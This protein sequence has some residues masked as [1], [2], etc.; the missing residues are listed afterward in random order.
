MGDPDFTAFYAAGKIVRAG[1]GA[2]LYTARTQLGTQREFTSDSDIRRG[3]LPYIHPPFEALIFL[4]LTFLS[5]RYA[6]VSWELLNLAML[7]GAVLKLRDWSPALEHIPPWQLALAG[8]AFFPVFANFHQ[9]QDAILMLLVVVLA[10]RDLER[11]ADLRAGCWLGLGVFRYQ[12][13]VPLVLILGLWGRRKLLLGFAATTLAAGLLS[14]AVVGWPG[15]VQY[16][17]FVWHWASELSFGRTPPALM[18]NLLGLVTGWPGLTSP[19]WPGQLVVLACS[20]GLLIWIVA[21]GRFAN[22]KRGSQLGFACAVLAALLVGYSTNSYDLALLLLPLAIV[23]DHCLGES[24]MRQAERTAL[25]APAIPLLISPLWFFLWLRW[26]RINL[27]AVFLL[28][29][30]YAIAQEMRRLEKERHLEA[31]YS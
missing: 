26:E 18:P 13:I 29:W 5:Y 16:V 3:P 27:I 12:I 11:G 1:R 19:A 23:V 22:D 2:E 20:A 4:P 24:S 7:F 6:F 30:L 25:V 15:A 10:F 8:L 28:W 21:L 9:G 17:A 14:L 31:A